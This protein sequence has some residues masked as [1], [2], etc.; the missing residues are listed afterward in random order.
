MIIML[1]VY[2][3]LHLALCFYTV[4]VTGSTDGLVDIGQAAVLTEAATALA[5][6][7]GL[8]TKELTVDTRQRRSARPPPGTGTCPRPTPREV[9]LYQRGRSSVPWTQG[10]TGCALAILVGAGVGSA[11]VPDE[12]RDV[13]SYISRASTRAR[14]TEGDDPAVPDNSER[15]RAHRPPATKSLA[16]CG[17]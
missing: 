3:C 1:A 14:P 11:F 4:H 5:V 13:T 17:S 16:D 12:S 8:R 10:V 7:A 15:P 6:A 2:G 9:G